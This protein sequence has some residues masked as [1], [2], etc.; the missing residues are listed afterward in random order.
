[1]SHEYSI[2]ESIRQENNFNIG[3]S[4]LQQSEIQEKICGVVERVTYHDDASGW[5]VLKVA[6]FR[7]YG[8]LET[9]TVHQTRVFAGFTME[10]T[11]NWTQHPKFGR[12]FKAIFA[13]ELKPATASALEKYLGSG[14]IKGVGPKIAKRIV[15]HF[16]ERTLVVFEE[17]I[18]QLANVPGIAEKK[19][20]MIK[21]AWIEHRA[22]RDVMIFLQS[23]GISTL[24]AVRIYKQYG[25][26]SIAMV[27]ENPYRMAQDFYG[28]GFV[29]ADR[30]A[31]SIGFAPD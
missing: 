2:N 10:F 6:P 24:F 8:Q 16:G 15:R 9:V 30:V 31:L 4:M 21:S 13:A 5:S 14:L 25:D 18:D 1:M 3:S 27:R 17:E 28:I 19:L 29:T 7:S 26:D 11:G 22:I 20:A 23:H 12:Q